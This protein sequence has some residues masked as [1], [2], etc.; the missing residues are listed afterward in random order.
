ML[1]QVPPVFQLDTTDLDKWQ[2]NVEQ[3]AY[4]I[5]ENYL[6]GKDMF[7]L[8][9]SPIANQEPD[10]TRYEHGEYYCDICERLFI[11]K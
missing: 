11:G 9:Y 4:H 8:D 5:V 3:K 6:H 10:L 7:T 2:E 1:F